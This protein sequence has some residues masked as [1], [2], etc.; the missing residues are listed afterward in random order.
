[1]RAA[2]NS[3]LR[4]TASGL[5]E[6]SASLKAAVRGIGS[7]AKRFRCRGAGTGV[8]R[9]AGS[10]DS[11]GPPECGARYATDRKNG[12]VRAASRFTASTA[13]AV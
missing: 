10:S 6:T 3:G 13:L 8:A 9:F 1:M 12:S 5:S 2:P 11:R 7:A 4:R